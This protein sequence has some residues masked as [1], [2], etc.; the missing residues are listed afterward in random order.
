MLT[1]FILVGGWAQF[2]PEAYAAT[3]TA[4]TTTAATLRPIRTTDTRTAPSRPSCPAT[5]DGTPPRAIQQA[6]RVAG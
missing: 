4:L 3:T 2:G 6:P 5:S 1:A